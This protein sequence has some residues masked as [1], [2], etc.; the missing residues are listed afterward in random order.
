MSIAE[1]IT[2]IAENVPKVFE[3]GQKSEYDRFWDAYQQNGNRYN[4]NCSFGE[5]VWTDEIY[6]P[7]YGFGQPRYIS[8]MF[9][10]SQITDTKQPLDLTAV[11][12]DNIGGLFQSCMKLVTIRQMTVL[13]RHILSTAFNNCTAL[14]NI[15]FGGVIGRDI[16]FQWS[17][18]LSRASIENIME[19]LSTTDSG[20]SITFSK[21]AVDAAFTDEEWA[22][23]ANTRPNWTIN[24]I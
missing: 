23:L 10:Q 13:E 9:S 7:K 20:Q 14:E 24:L 8:S 17:P 21:T 5:T 4:Y 12:S 18:K 1:K 3:A 15:T 22:T 11:S 6:D 16:N 2:T 19:H